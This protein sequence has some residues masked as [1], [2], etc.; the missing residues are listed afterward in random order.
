MPQK[1]PLPLTFERVTK[2]KMLPISHAGLRVA[3]LIGAPVPS[4]RKVYDLALRGAFPATFENGRWFVAEQDIPAV[5]EA[6]G[7][8]VPS[9]DIASAA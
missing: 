2:R 6:L 4:P 7:F 9:G 5:A 3:A 1:R 8:D